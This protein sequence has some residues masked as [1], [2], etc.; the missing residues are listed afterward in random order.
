[1]TASRRSN[2]SFEKNKNE[3]NR[4]PV[5]TFLEEKA[6]ADAIALDASRCIRSDDPRLRR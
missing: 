5:S 4:D 2:A 1:M 6:D 3:V